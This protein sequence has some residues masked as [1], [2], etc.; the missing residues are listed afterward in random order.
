MGRD[1]FQFKQFLVHQKRSAMRVGTDGV[2]LG[3]W[4]PVNEKPNLVLDIGT[5][6]GLIA[7]MLAQRCTDATI[8]GVEADVEAF[9]E[10]R[11]N[12]AASKWSRRLVAIYSTFQQYALSASVK[13]DMMVCNPPFFSDGVKS[14]C[15]KRRLA[16]HNDSMSHEDILDGCSSLIAP[17]GRLGIVL[18]VGVFSGFQITAARRGWFEHRRMWVRPTPQKP[19][20]RVVSLWGI[21]MSDSVQ[22]EEMTLELAHHR[23]SLEF[24]VLTEEFY[25]DNQ[26]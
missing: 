4:L 17:G 23:Y 12:F 25:L 10:A 5:G 11:A 9:G 20:K 26:E 6:T 14:N 21:Q 2:L 19:A 8:H 24:K 13:Y 3:A 22:V 15:S 18:P 1:Y 16:R 7:L